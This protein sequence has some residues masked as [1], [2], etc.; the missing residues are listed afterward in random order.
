VTQ[1][2][3]PASNGTI[4]YS[5]AT[6]YEDITEATEVY[7]GRDVV[8]L[9]LLGQ[10]N[11]ASDIT[12]IVAGRDV[13]YPTQT[14]VPGVG[15]S[16]SFAIEIGGPGNVVVEAGRNVNLGN[17][18]GI[19]TFGNLLNS[20]LPSNGGASITIQAGLGTSALDYSTFIAQF[21]DPASSLYAEPLQLFNPSS[22]G[23]T[24]ALAYYSSLVS[25][26]GSM[27]TSQ[28]LLINRIFFSLLRDSG[29]E[30]TGAT[31]ET[32]YELGETIDTIAQFNGAYSNYQRAFAAIAAF[33]PTMSATGSFFGGLSTVRTQEGGNITIL[34]PTGQVQ[35]G[36]TSPPTGF[37]GYSNPTDPTYALDFGIVTERGGDIDIYAEGDISVNQSRIFTLGGGDMTI[38]SLD[39][40]IDAGKGAKTVQA[41]QPPS[42]SFDTYGNITI[43]PYG[44][45]SGSGIATLRALPGV[46]AGN[47]D[48]LAPG[49]FI[50]FGDAG[51]RVS[52]NLSVAT[53]IVLNASN[54][55]VAGRVTGIPIVAPP[56]IGALTTAGNVAGSASKATEAPNDCHD[57]S[58][59]KN[60]HPS[61]IIVE[62]L[63][64]GGS[65]ACDN[66]TPS[67]GCKGNGAPPSELRKKDD[68][69]SYDPA[70]SVQYVGVGLLSDDQK[71]KLTPEELSNLAVR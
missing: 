69:Q 11:N 70:S 61:V 44:P 15:F 49:G 55:Q 45:A 34:A 24:D 23:P 62:V 20:S 21:I 41:I 48:L 52:G 36:L 5:F 25:P 18:A 26:S 27:S 3:T 65:D 16:M 2:G 47:V 8:S 68:H 19:Q 30:H 50:N 29:R 53:P 13:T 37:P 12:S 71:S 28:E 14:N 58:N 43:T 63:G 17:S 10:N 6:S 35:V 22:N 57:N 7:A 1:G 40:S 31:G 67:G 54:V 66:P 42:V 33:I 59:C 56:D 4:V 38:M 39:G 64:Y 9:A 60:D 51:L 32:N 46:P